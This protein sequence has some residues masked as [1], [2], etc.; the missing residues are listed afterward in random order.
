[1]TGDPAPG[2]S[3]S[4][5]A[6]FTRLGR[7]HRRGLV[8]LAVLAAT[9]L[10]ASLPHQPSFAQTVDTLFVST[11]GTNVC[12]GGFANPVDTVEHAIDCAK[13]NTSFVRI[14]VLCA[15]LPLCDFALPQ[16]FRFEARGRSMTLQGEPD[17]TVRFQVQTIAIE[18]QWRIQGVIFDGNKSGTEPSSSSDFLSIEGDDVDLVH[19]E[20]K[21]T[22][23]ECIGI[24]RSSPQHHG[25][26][27]SRNYI[28]NCHGTTTGGLDVHCIV[29]ATA[30]DVT[31]E[32]NDITE[33]GGDGYQILNDES[34]ASVDVATDNTIRGN[35]I[36]ASPSDTA[37]GV[38]VRWGENGIDIKRAGVNL[39]IQ[40]NLIWGYRASPGT[41]PPT[42]SEQGT[43]SSDPTGAGIVVQGEIEDGAGNRCSGSPRCAWVEGNDVSDSGGG[44]VIGTSD[45]SQN[46][47]KTRG[48]DVRGNYIHDLR[49]LMSAEDRRRGVGI[50]LATVDAPTGGGASPEFNRVYRNLIANVP[51][52]SFWVDFP[53]P[54]V[55]WKF[56]IYN[57]LITSAGEGSKCYPLDWYTPAPKYEGNRWFNAPTP[58]TLGADV[59]LN[60][61]VQY[62]DPLEN[63]TATIPCGQQ[64]S[65]SPTPPSGYDGAS[66]DYRYAWA[67]ESAGTANP[68]ADAALGGAD[69]VE[70]GFGLANCGAADVGPDENCASDNFFF[71]EDSPP[72]ASADKEYATGSY[73]W[74]T[75]PDIGV[76]ETATT[77]YSSPP[78]ATPLDIETP[79]FS[80]GSR[81]AKL[82]VRIRT[83]LGSAPASLHIRVWAGPLNSGLPFPRDWT[84]YVNQE[85]YPSRAMGDDRL[86]GVY[87]RLDQSV[88]EGWYVYGFIW[89][90]PGANPTGQ[91]SEE[92]FC[93]RAEVSASKATNLSEND[94]RPPFF[95]PV[96]RSNNRAQ[97]NVSIIRHPASSASG[98]IFAFAGPAAQFILVNH[99]A[100]DR[101]VYLF[102]PPSED[103]LWRPE[104]GPISEWVGDWSEEE[105]DGLTRLP[106]GR[107]VI[108]SPSLGNGPHV[109]QILIDWGDREAVAPEEAIEVTQEGGAGFTIILQSAAD[110]GGRD[111][112]LP[113]GIGVLVVVVLLLL[114]AAAF[115]WRW[116]GRGDFRQATT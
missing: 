63:P 108:E 35:R 22:P 37:S 54:D 112:L 69:F 32:Y 20:I 96:Y 7:S 58:N 2:G 74:W 42:V 78:V 113:W 18:S 25:I 31:I 105:R 66:Y 99:A 30:T 87:E 47:G 57:N 36:W 100:P 88:T 23:R 41:N 29:N 61:P 71:R 92:H 33:C 85:V 49:N 70:R 65:M 45:S 64:P 83:K 50:M 52:V 55:A 16:T 109:G 79:E 3:F 9:S 102:F 95:T 46:L 111:W 51:G 97:R 73:Y 89:T 24:P 76:L 106:A 82:L 4:S 77:T 60:S 67:Y 103:D 15:S 43:G 115:K 10:L 72:T 8:R 13:N 98:P 38:K 101:A 14:V 12:V 59:K 27:I 40:D 104:D 91:K 107:S 114:T 116:R 80:T 6:E 1:V 53:G 39:K 94:S 44:I 26:T 68:L 34:E 110:E 86:A 93:I 62:L 28:H 19:N 11:Q 75:S 48:I 21:N 17:H 90:V 5:A 56:S 81:E 84:M